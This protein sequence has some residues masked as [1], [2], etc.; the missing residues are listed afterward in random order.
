M[1][2]TKD[3]VNRIHGSGQGISTNGNKTI[4]NHI[5]TIVR[6][7][8]PTKDKV[9]ERN[10]FY[11]VQEADKNND[12]DGFHQ[13]MGMTDTHLTATDLNAANMRRNGTSHGQRRTTNFF[14]SN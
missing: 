7:K 3:N 10:I 9:E 5:K 8:N 14:T 2:T 6:N 11:G 1:H 4:V 12:S 13:S